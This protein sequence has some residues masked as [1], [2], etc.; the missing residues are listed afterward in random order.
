MFNPHYLGQ[1]AI[2]SVVNR[3]KV[4]KGTS[5]KIYQYE[6]E[7]TEVKLSDSLFG[8]LL[9]D[10]Y[11]F[12]STSYSRSVD[13]ANLGPGK[14]RLEFRLSRMRK[15]IERRVY[16]LLNALSDIGGIFSAIAVV[17]TF[18]VHTFCTDLFYIEILNR[19]F[20]RINPATK[21]SKPK[22]EATKQDETPTAHLIK[23]QLDRRVK[24]NFSLADIYKYSL[25]S[26]FHE[27]CRWLRLRK[28]S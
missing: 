20:L 10:E 15:S 23:D 18:I 24:F 1:K 22:S 25:M 19:T 14:V 21:D 6:I 8:N 5:G 7:G 26:K 11:T 16:S 3:K 9:D 27:L 12:F 28:N 2:Q 4:S 17:F 13:S